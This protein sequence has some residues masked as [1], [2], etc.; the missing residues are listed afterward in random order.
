M[1]SAELRLRQQ[2]LLVRSALLRASIAQQVQAYG[3]ALTVIDRVY[4]GVLWL[5]RNPWLPLG[6]LGVALVFR[7]HN[8][9]V[10]AGRMWSLGRALW[11]KV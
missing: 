11:W 4:A 5:Q 7:P 2:H 3:P 9:M 8:A 1:S 10:W 6:V